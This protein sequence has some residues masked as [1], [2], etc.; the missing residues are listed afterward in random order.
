MSQILLREINKYNNSIGYF[1][2]SKKLS[3]SS[4]DIYL[5]TSEKNKPIILNW[6]ESRC[7]TALYG[8]IEKMKTIYLNLLMQAIESEAPFT[9]VNT[10][11]QQEEIEDKIRYKLSNTPYK[12]PVYNI[13]KEDLENKNINLLSK[14]TSMIVHY[15]NSDVN[16][17]KLLRASFS[18]SFANTFN[19][20]NNSVNNNSTPSIHKIMI[21]AYL[22][23]DIFFEAQFIALGRSLG[24]YN[25]LSNNELDFCKLANTNAS[26]LL[27]DDN[28]VSKYKEMLELFQLRQVNEFNY[29]NGVDALKKQIKSKNNLN[30]NYKVTLNENESY[31]IKNNAEISKLVDIKQFY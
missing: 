14:E 23:S 24:I 16:E 1:S 13:E 3:Y 11:F 5:A 17:N 19:N 20:M 28:N 31:V 21:L 26:I 22:S 25:F 4:T 12:Y 27:S 15:H 18:H 2:K 7:A 30:T 29:I 6:K 10:L 8:C 9:I